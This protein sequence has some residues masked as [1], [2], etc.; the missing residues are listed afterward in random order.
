MALV[1]CP[2]CQKRI[3]SQAKQCSH[4]KVSLSGNTESLAKISHIQ[5]SNKLMNHSLIFLTLFIGGAVAW[6]WGG[7]QA[8]GYQAIASVFCFII[9]FVGYLITRVRLVIHKRKSV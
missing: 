2:K 6:F 8:Q 3:S 7:E 1:E 4:C 5:Q 9:G